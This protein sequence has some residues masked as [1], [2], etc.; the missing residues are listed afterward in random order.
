VRPSRSRRPSPTRC[1]LITR[2]HDTPGWTSKRKR[3]TSG[4]RETPPGGGIMSAPA[5]HLI[6]AIIRTG[7]LET[8]LANGITADVVGG[9]E[10]EWDYITDYHQR[11]GK[12]PPEAK[13]KRNFPDFTV[14]E[15][16][17]V[18]ASADETL[19]RHKSKEFAKLAQSILE[20]VEHDDLGE[21]EKALTKALSNGLRLG[22]S[23]GSSTPAPASAPRSA[24]RRR[25]LGRR[26]CPRHDASE[27]P[28]ASW[29]R[30]SAWRGTLEPQNHQIRSLVLCVDLVGSRR[31]WP[32]QVGCLVDLVGSR[33]VLS[34]R[35][36]NQARQF[37]EPGR[38]EHKI[39]RLMLYPQKTQSLPTR[40][41]TGSE[42]GPLTWRPAFHTPTMWAGS[43]RMVMSASG[44]PSTT[45]RS[46]S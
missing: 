20:G 5:Q 4:H 14:E 17:D 41:S 21:S 28:T 10:P 32:A 12:L 26:R 23:T 33:R 38:V 29:V 46:A 15:V 6:S 3:S 44:S 31:I 34:D 39:Q 13:I 2:S 18:P 16:D 8:A 43:A 7:D 19:H 9:F 25:A 24:R 27:S 1:Q 37:D 35:L 40:W 11:Y 42:G 36:D 45:M 22:G 30:N